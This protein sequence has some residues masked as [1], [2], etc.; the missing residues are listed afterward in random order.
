MKLKLAIVSSALTLTALVA[1]AGLAW[2]P[3]APAV[4]APAADAFT[5]DSVHSSVVFRIKHFNT[6]YFYGRFNNP[7][8]TFN[9]D[10]ANPSASTLQVSVKTADVDTNNK[11]RDEHLSKEEFFSAKEYPTI[12]YTGK[13]FKKLDD[14]RMEIT[15]EL[16]MRGQ[17]RPLNAVIEHTG[18]GKGRV[19]EALSGIE[20]RLVINRSEWGVS[21]L[22]GPLSDEVTLMIALEGA[23][24]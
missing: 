4:A 17:T 1:G 16:T 20:T 9:L 24:K 3:A 12:T 10:F 6:S 7:T 5:V 8:G 18:S 19:G 23:R 2:S 21:A 13:T 15:G 22:V 11:A 14:H